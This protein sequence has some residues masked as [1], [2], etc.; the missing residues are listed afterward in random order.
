MWSNSVKNLERNFVRE[1]CTL[2][3]LSSN[4]CIG[5]LVALLWQLLQ[6]RDVST[7][8]VCHRKECLTHRASVAPVFSHAL[9]L[10]SL[11]THFLYFLHFLRSVWVEEVEV[12]EPEVPEVPCVETAGVFGKLWILGP[13]LPESKIPR[14]HFPKVD[15]VQRSTS[16]RS[17]PS[18]LWSR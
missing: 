3:T 2:F 13:G 7:L 17:D 12:Q 14:N 4:Y 11:F 5:H 9:Y 8:W 15:V 18:K 10:R 16:H 1:I 6:H